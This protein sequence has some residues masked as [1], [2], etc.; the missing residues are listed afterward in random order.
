MQNPFSIQLSETALLIQGKHKI[1]KYIEKIKGREGKNT[2][3]FVPSELERSSLGALHDI[4]GFD[5]RLS[6]DKIKSN[7]SKNGNTR[8]VAEPLDSS[9]N[10]K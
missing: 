5:S 7:P 10:A 2:T 6:L 9:A 3:D 8:E 4:H 1:N